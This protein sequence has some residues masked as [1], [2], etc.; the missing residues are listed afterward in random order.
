MS[1]S[2]KYVDPAFQGVGHKVGTEIWRIEN[3]QPVPIPKSDY[4]K[5]Y[6]GDS[7]IILQV[8]FVIFS[9]FFCLRMRT[10]AL[11]FT[12]TSYGFWDLYKIH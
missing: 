8:N 2:T 7:Y 6:S 12:C 10:V 11:F 9:L 1:S 3:F 4:G 5:F